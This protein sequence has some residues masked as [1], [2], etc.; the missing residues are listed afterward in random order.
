MPEEHDSHAF[1]RTTR[2]QGEGSTLTASASSKLE[3][4]LNPT[5]ICPAH[6]PKHP[7]V[8]FNGSIYFR[9]KDCRRIKQ[10]LRRAKHGYTRSLRRT[11]E[12]HMVPYFV[13]LATM[14]WNMAESCD[15]ASQTSS[16]VPSV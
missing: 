3:P 12:A 9:C 16:E 6:G 11:V 8:R 7:F 14:R 15:P 4:M 13:K 2:F 1:K 5:P 10:K